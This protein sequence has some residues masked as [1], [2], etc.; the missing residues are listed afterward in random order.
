MRVSFTDD[1]DSEEARESDGTVNTIPPTASDGRV[2]VIENQD[3]TFTAA[4]FNYADSNGNPLAS[5]T[6][7]F[8]L[9]SGTGALKLDNTVVRLDEVVITAQLDAGR[10]TYTPPQDQTGTGFAFFIFAVSDGEVGSKS[11]YQMHIDI[12]EATSAPGQPRNLAAVP[13]NG[14]VALRWEAP[15]HPGASAIVRYEVRHAAGAAVAGGHSLGVR[16]AQPDAHGHRAD[17][18]PTLH[19][20]GAGGE[21]LD[22]G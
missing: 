18:R 13:G 11:V 19:V 1:L 12:A 22:R 16:R 4:D 10:L 21:R 5:V 14:A 17:E 20:R 2:T 8:R 3:Y 6:I 9:A 15:V 7:K